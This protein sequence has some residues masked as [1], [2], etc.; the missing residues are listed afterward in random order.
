MRSLRGPGNEPGKRPPGRSSQRGKT[1]KLH[2]PAAVW[3]EAVGTAGDFLAPGWS[4]VR[5]VWLKY[6]WPV[7]R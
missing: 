7:S 1:S 3:S 2:P 6:V 4:K 5:A